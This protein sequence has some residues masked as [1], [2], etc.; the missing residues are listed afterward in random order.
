MENKELI[1]FSELLN[2]V[3]NNKSRIL[4]HHT[5]YESLILIL[6]GHSI[7]LTRYDLMNDIAEKE[8]S[9]CQT[10]DN[11]YIAS[12]TSAQ[13]ES[14]AM[15]ALYGKN[16]SLKLRLAFPKDALV[17]SVSNNFYFDS[18]LTERIPVWKTGTVNSDISKKGFSLSNIVYYDRDKSQLRLDGKPLK[19]LKVTENLI[20]E[21]AGTIKYD[22]WEYEKET[23]L[24][25]VLHQEEDTPGD[26]T[27]IYAKL[28]DE[29]IKKMT[30]IYNPWI[31]D[32][33]FQVLS[34]NID[35]IA[36]FK[37]N[38][39]KSDLHGEITEL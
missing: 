21:L 36:G 28:T 9:K 27:H 12:F 11:R 39:K 38:H 5:S 3:Y 16:S 10:G 29:L 18:A 34:E 8:L 14:V 31:N 23:R 35:N 2:K 25:V 26:I 22:A 7:R 19:D 30:V 4:Y 37:L 1:P 6:K 20:S 32:T 13:T 15:W 33:L 24:S 17:S